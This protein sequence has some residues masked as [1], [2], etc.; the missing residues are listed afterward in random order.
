M[1]RRSESGPDPVRC[2]WHVGSRDPDDV[3]SLR[4]YS[5]ASGEHIGT[6][7]SP[8]L[9]LAAVGGHNRDLKLE[10]VVVLDPGPK[11]EGDR[12]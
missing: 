9:A 5:A 4:V 2:Y 12:G 10:R 11:R 3:E 7:L 8:S 6:F 1:S